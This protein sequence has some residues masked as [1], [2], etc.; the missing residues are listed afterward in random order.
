MRSTVGDLARWGGALFTPG[1]VL[2]AEHG[3]KFDWTRPSN[4]VDLDLPEW[5]RR[6]KPHTTP[7]AATTAAL[8]A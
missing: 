6:R 5:T 2:P 3:M 1:R 8:P 4:G 7:A